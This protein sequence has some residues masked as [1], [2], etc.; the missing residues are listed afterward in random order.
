MFAVV[1]AAV[2]ALWW[3]VGGAGYPWPAWLT[4][5]WGLGLVIE[6][7]EIYGLGKVAPLER[8]CGGDEED[9]GG[10]RQHGPVAEREAPE[11]GGGRRVG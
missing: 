7:W 4:G 1:N 3:T 8:P 6:A 5:A 11:E 2:W 9:R 10:D